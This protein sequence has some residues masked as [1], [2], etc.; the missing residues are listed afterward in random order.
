MNIEIGKVI[1]SEEFDNLFYY[2]GNDLGN[3][4]IL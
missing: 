2:G 4:Y 3:I 1:C